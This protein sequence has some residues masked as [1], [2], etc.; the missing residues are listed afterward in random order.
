MAPQGMT[1]PKAETENDPADRPAQ[2]NRASAARRR[3]RSM[4]FFMISGPDGARE[5][6]EL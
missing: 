2:K 6:S 4:G 3:L 5:G 1:I